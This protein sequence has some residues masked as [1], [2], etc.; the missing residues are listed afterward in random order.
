MIPSFASSKSANLSLSQFYN[1]ATTFGNLTPS[2]VCVPGSIF[3]INLW[4]FFFSGRFGEEEAGSFA[5]L[6][7]CLSGL[8]DSRL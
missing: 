6:L 4:F 5:Y 8:I 7:A 2:F 1:F 3:F